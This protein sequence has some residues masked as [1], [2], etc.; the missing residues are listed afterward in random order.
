VATRPSKHWSG[1]WVIW[2]PKTPLVCLAHGMKVG[3]QVLGPWGKKSVTPELDAFQNAHFTVIQQLH[4]ITPFANEHKR[5][6]RQ[7]NLHS[8]RAWL[9]KMHMQRFQQVA[10]RLC[11]DM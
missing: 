4:L 6:L 3:F 5:Q 8:G 9:A 2:T 1:P 10:L 7:D 11:R